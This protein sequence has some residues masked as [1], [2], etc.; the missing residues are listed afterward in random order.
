MEKGKKELRHIS[1][2][3]Y[4]TKKSHNKRADGMPFEH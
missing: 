1:S 3:Y 2:K 4:K